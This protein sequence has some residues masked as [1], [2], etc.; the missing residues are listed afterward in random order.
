MARQ[1]INFVP[2]NYY[3]I[4]NRGN[5][6]QEIFFEDENYRFFLQRLH[7]YFTPAGIDLIAY[8]L[9]PNHF[10][11][12]VRLQRELDFSNTMRSFS[13]SYVKS[14]NLWHRRVGHLFQCDFQAS[15]VDAERYLTHHC[16]Y[17]HLNPMNAGLVSNP[18]EW[19]FSDYREWISP[20][21]Y[22]E[23]A[24]VRMRKEL[25]GTAGEYQRF[26]IDYADE[27]RMQAEINRL[28]FGFA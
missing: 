15:H 17:I 1:E 21:K 5:N 11:L 8:C 27:Q 6:Q 2:E 23:K 14:F 10:H 25:F 12:L 9:L 3:H 26:V 19:E 22:T 7:H 16:R 4:Y 24:N 20:N 18:E 28:L 13:T